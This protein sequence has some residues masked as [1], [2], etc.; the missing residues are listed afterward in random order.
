MVAIVAGPNG[1]GKSTTAPPLLRDTL[2]LLD[3]VNADTVALGLS[4]F[5]PDGAG[6]AAGRIVLER[7]RELGR[8]RRSFAFETTLATRSFA[9]WL[10][11][12]A[13]TGY[14]VALMFLW[15][16]SPEVAIARVAARVRLGGHDVPEATVR[17][18]YAR[19]LGNFFQLY[20]PIASTWRIYDSSTPARPL[21]AAGEG[22]VVS[23]VG[24]PA[25]WDR[26]KVEH[27]FAT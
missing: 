4:G 9:P 6:P 11:E 25:R 24:A 2:G 16:A 13:S 21:I 5:D 14:H 22:T 18:R 20:A 12:L 15:L 10:R 17:R 23:T 27:G 8:A 3:F 1:A 26:M 19:G 7:L